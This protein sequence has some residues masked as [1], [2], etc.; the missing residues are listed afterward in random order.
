MDIKEPIFKP[1]QSLEQVLYP[2][3]QSFHEGMLQVS[4]LHSIYYAEYGNPQGVPILVVH[5]GPGAGCNPISARHMDPT[6]YRIILVDQ[7]GAPRSTPRGEMQENNTAHL[8]E[9]FEKLRKHL[10]ITKWILNGGSWGVALS[11]A[12]G[13]AHPDVV[14]G[15]VLRGV[16]LARKTEL[17]NWFGKRA[18]FPEKWDELVNFIPQAE[19]DDIIQALYTRIMDNDSKIHMPAAMAFA[20]FGFSG[21]DLFGTSQISTALQDEKLVLSLSRSFSHY[22]MNNCFFTDNQLIENIARI[23]HLPAIIVQ[24]RLDLITLPQTAYDLHKSWPGSKLVFV[25]DG[26]HSPLDPSISKALVEATEEMKGK[27]I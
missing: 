14:L 25:P 27:H 2:M 7:R 3:T 18:F 13:E 11:I 9:D 6:Y 8:I 26:G 4:D 23:S 24:G 17:Q 10:G 5:G 20:Q 19:R 1:D 16:F 15:F 12:Y 22:F 21:Q